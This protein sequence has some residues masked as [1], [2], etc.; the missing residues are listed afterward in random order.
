MDHSHAMVSGSFSC[1]GQWAI[2][3]PWSVDHS[4]AMISDHSHAMVSAFIYVYLLM[5]Q[6]EFAEALALGSDS[7]FVSQMFSVI[8]REQ[9]GFISFRDMIYAVV[10]FSKGTCEDKLHL[11]FRMYDIDKSGT[12]D[13]EEISKMIRCVK[14]H[15]KQKLIMS[16]LTACYYAPRLLRDFGILGERVNSNSNAMEKRERFEVWIFDAGPWW[17]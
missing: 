2:L 5:F 16:S 13:R 3:M 9:K 6:E 7:L 11:L 15:C 10:V 1:H 4:H 8:D 17:R 14:L 12:L